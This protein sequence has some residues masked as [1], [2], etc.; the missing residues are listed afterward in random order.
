MAHISGLVAARVRLTLPTFTSS[1][2]IIKTD[3]NLRPKFLYVEYAAQRRQYGILF[4]FSLFR[5]YIHLEY[6]RL[7]V[8][9]RVHQAEYG[10]HILVAASQEY[11]NTFPTFLF[12]F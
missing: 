4:I 1:V 3:R 6:V 7:P 11:V 10:T 12:S 8:I 9:Y 2:F 5:E